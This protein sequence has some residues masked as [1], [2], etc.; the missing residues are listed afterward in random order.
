MSQQF[1]TIRFPHI[2]IM[3]TIST[4]ARTG[5]VSEEMNMVQY[6][7][8]EMVEVFGQLA[9]DRLLSGQTVITEESRYHQTTTVCASALAIAA[10]T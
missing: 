6:S 4:Q 10:L 8:E 5:R 3:R 2:C 1:P 9:T 7:D